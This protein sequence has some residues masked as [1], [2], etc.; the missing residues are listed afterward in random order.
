MIREAILCQ[1]CSFFN[2]VHPK[3]GEELDSIV[4]D[5]NPAEDGE[6]SEKTH[7]SSDEAKL[8]FQGHPLVLLHLVV[9]GDVKE[10]LNE[11][12]LCFVWRG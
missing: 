12:D 11:V 6:A 9:G 4:D 8:G 1:K 5:L 10:Y 3:R 7:C 2:I